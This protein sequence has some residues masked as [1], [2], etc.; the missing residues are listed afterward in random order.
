LL[1]LVK[2]AIATNIALSLLFIY[3][4]YTIW[5]L[6][7]GNNIA[8]STL[9][10]SGWN[11][12]TINVVFSSYSNGAFATVQGIFTYLNS[13]YLLFWVLMVTNMYFILK[14]QKSKQLK[15]GQ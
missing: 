12:L 13:P 3:S 2:Y 4:N 5:E 6:F 9:I 10:S 8:H 1:K 15:E 7:R 11:P 14:L